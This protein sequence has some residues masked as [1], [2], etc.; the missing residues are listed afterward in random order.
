MAYYYNSSYEH[1]ALNLDVHIYEFEVSEMHR[2]FD[3]NGGVDWRQTHSNMMYSKKDYGKPTI[4]A[5][6]STDAIKASIEIL[7]MG[8][9]PVKLLNPKAHD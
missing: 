4:I 2:D 9:T 6:V 5:I 1:R 7:D 8:Y 3:K